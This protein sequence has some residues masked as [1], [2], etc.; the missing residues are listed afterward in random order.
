MAITTSPMPTLFVGHGNPMHAIGSG[1]WSRAF[2]ALSGGLP[3]PRAILSISA[4]WYVDGTFT[5]GNDAPRTIHDFS[6]FPTA[7]HNVTY[8]AP[9][10]PELA[11]RVA[12]L[13]GPGR[14][15]VR[16]DWGLDHGTWSVLLR[17]YPLAQVPVVQLSIDRRLSLREHAELAR[18]LAPL[19]DDGILIFGSGNV[20][21]NLGDA[22]KRMR[23]ANT[24]TPDWAKR[25]VM[26]QFEKLNARLLKY[27]G[28]RKEVII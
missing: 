8:P 12:N 16:H 21:H 7:L 24:D 10:A 27:M 13:L 19:R 18:H 6:G 22:F 20:T 11:A 3:M 26:G 17:A 5:T 14:A 25:R 1:E 2:A 23:T 28:N 9:G 4:H 15:S